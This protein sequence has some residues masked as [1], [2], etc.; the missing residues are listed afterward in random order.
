MIKINAGLTD[1]GSGL[2]FDEAGN[3]QLVFLY[4][5][6]ECELKFSMKISALKGLADEIRDFVEDNDL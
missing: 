2:E 5:F 3:I 6:M 1:L 4:D